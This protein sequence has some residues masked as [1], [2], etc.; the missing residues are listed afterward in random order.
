MSESKRAR[1]E[2]SS[3]RGSAGVSLISSSLSLMEYL[4]REGGAREWLTF[5]EELSLSW[6]Q[7]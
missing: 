1:T 5:C 2:V 6:L 4:D 7:I 3:L